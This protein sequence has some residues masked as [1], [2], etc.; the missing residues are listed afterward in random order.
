MDTSTAHDGRK[1]ALRKKR[2]RELN[3]NNRKTKQCK[4]APPKDNEMHQDTTPSAEPVYVGRMKAVACSGPAAYDGPPPWQTAS[5]SLDQ[6]EE[7][8]ESRN[9]SQ[10]A[11]VRTLSDE[12][13]E[14]YRQLAKSPCS[15]DTDSPNEEKYDNETKTPTLSTILEDRC[16]QRAEFEI[17]GKRRC[18]SKAI[19]WQI[20]PNQTI[21]RA[22]T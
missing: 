22:H 13:F 5:H 21:K 2:K 6:Y 12:S 14:M 20:Q 17:S 8:S 11:F 16:F 3:Y 19:S 9:I 15:S 1:S 10:A 4:P 18:T 7:A